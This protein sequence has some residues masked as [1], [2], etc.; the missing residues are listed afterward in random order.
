MPYP[1]GA[2]F[3]VRV[4][5]SPVCSPV[6]WTDTSRA[7]VRCFI[8]FGAECSKGGLKGKRGDG[9]TLAASI[10]LLLVTGLRHFAF[11]KVG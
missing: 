6:P 9:S 8:R 2:G 5:G 11:R 7:S 3:I 1:A 4:T 10:F